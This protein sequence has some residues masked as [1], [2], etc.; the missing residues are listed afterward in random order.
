MFANSRHACILRVDWSLVFRPLFRIATSKRARKKTQENKKAS[1]KEEE[2][3]ENK[4]TKESNDETCNILTTQPTNDAPQGCSMMQRKC[5][6]SAPA[7][8]NQIQ[9]TI[10]KTINR[11]SEY[12]G[13]V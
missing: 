3:E 12:D 7:R 9:K 4:R 5:G 13:R 1:N 2:R 8:I 10:Q 6:T 11:R